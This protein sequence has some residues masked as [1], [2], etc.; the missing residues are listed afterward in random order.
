M[1]SLLSHPFQQIE[2]LQS[3]NH[4]QQDLAKDL[5]EW[6]I[7]KSLHGFK[8]TLAGTIPLDIDTDFSDVDILV[9]FNNPAHLQKIC[10][11]KFRNMPNYSFSE[12][13][14]ALCVTLI[15]RFET[16]KFSYEIF[17]Q[18][19]EPTDQYAWIH[20]MVENRFLSFADPTFR[21]EIRNLKKQGIKTEPAFCKVLDLKGDP[22]QTLLQWNEKSEDQF[23]EL[24][25]QKG[26]HIIPN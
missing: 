6:K 14:I 21:E 25:V 13:N 17:G 4:K 12:K 9:K 15:C 18:S 19:V 10:Y 22:Y 3:G 5:D 8:P 16:K 24:L 23:R 2:F 20:M 7:L 1:Q 11:A 26:F